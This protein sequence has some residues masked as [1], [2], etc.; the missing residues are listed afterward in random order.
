MKWYFL[1]LIS[2]LF[3]AVEVAFPPSWQLGYCHPELALLLAVYLSLNAE[4]RE[5][6]YAA[7][8][9]GLTKDLFSTGRMGTHAILFLGGSLTLLAL[10]RF[11][12]R[13]EIL[14]QA[15]IALAAVFVSS[16]VYILQMRLVLPGTQARAWFGHAAVVSL[17]SAAC[18]PIVFLIL[19]ILRKPLGA[20]ERLR[21]Y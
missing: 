21:L 15:C 4:P 19:D 14:V 8:L 1:I 13:D 5:A 12:Y 7:W 9:V 3:A 20:Y 2:F 18:A 17:Y 11:F 16:L 6:P 10:R